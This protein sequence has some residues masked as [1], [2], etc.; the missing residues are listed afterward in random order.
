MSDEFNKRVV[1]AVK[2][3]KQAAEV[4][5]KLIAVAQ[6][7]VIYSEPVTAEGHTV[8]TASELSVAMG[9]GYGGGIGTDTE[10]AEGEILSENES[11]DGMDGAGIGYGG[12]GGGVSNG[13]PVAIISIGSEGVQVQP[14]MDLTKITLAVFTTL[15]SMLFMLGKMRKGNQR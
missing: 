14:V 9:F 8:I 13:R 3:H 10:M 15:G 1:T 4:M 5:E 6:P 7:G 11:Q 2:S 12:G